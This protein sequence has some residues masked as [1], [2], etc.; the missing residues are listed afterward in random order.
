MGLV[1]LQ[2]VESSCIGDLTHISC[3]SM[4]TL[5]LSHQGSPVCYFLNRSISSLEKKKKNHKWGTSVKL[6]KEYTVKPAPSWR[7]WAFSASGTPPQPL[8]L[9]L[10][11]P[12]PTVL[13]SKTILPVFEVAINEPIQPTWFSAWLFMPGVVFL[14]YL[15]IVIRSCS[16][17]LW[18]C[19]IPGYLFIHVFPF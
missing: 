13:A 14:R 2:H 10:S 3:I 7:K 16:S 15:H 9:C 1:A 18:F 11:R 17:F 19:S 12:T 4:W 5:P 6:H 8:L